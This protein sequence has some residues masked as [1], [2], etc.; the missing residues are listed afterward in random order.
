MVYNVADRMK[1][2]RLEI[3]SETVGPRI[4]VDRKL[5]SAYV[6]P[7]GE[8]RARCREGKVQVLIGTK[9]LDMTTPVAVKVGISLAKNGGACQ[10]LGD[11]VLLEIGGEEFH[12]L[13]EIA[14]ALSGAIIRKADKAD[15]WQRGIVKG[16]LQ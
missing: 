1:G 5:I 2:E 9:T 4:V 14:M 6:P 8:I 10:Y 15:D 12:L 16:D 13:P 7:Q 3:R 11:I